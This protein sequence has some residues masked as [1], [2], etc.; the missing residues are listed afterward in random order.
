MILGW[1]NDS[2]LDNNGAG[3]D[4]GHCAVPNM[5]G[6]NSDAEQDHGGAGRLQGMG[7]MSGRLHTVRFASLPAIGLR[8]HLQRRFSNRYLNE[9]S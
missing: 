5:L 2:K 9:F 7:E 3:V 6:W 1:T 4:H 8:N